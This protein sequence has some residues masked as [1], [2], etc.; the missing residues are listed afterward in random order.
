MKDYFTFEPYNKY[1]II[2]VQHTML[3][4]NAY[5][6]TLAFVPRALAIKEMHFY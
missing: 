3:N 4:K 5:R 2:N 1:S 6:Y